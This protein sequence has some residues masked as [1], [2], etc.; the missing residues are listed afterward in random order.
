MPIRVLFVEDQPNILKAQ[1]KLLK[2][3]VES[4]DEAAGESK[5]VKTVLSSLL[6]TLTV[7]NSDAGGMKKE[8]KSLRS[9]MTPK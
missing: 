8:L 7:L 9:L 1:V 5:E 4:A 6:D 2:T 3:F